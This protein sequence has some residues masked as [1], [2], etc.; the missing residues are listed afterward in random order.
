MDRF[1]P[2]NSTESNHK[3]QVCQEKLGASDS[4]AVSELFAFS[5]VEQISHPLCWKR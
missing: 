1:T 2:S 5:A 4:D 3:Q